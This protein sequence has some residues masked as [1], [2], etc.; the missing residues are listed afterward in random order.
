MFFGNHGCS[1]T[2]FTTFAAL[3]TREPAGFYE[4][5][6]G[7]WFHIWSRLARPR[8]HTEPAGI[9]AKTHGSWRE[10][11]ASFS[12]ARVQTEDTVCLP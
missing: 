1:T 4:H 6:V 2:S 11:S 9:S 5:G 10:R 7:V 8:K 3:S 12:R